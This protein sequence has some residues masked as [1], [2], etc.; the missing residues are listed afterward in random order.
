MRIFLTIAAIMSLVL[1]SFAMAALEEATAGAS[2]TVNTFVD[3][4]LTDTNGGGF[5]FGSDDPGTS[6]NAEADQSG[7]TPAATITREATSNVNVLVRLK[8]LDFTGAGT[9]A[10]NNAKFDD[11]ATVDQVTDTGLNQTRMTTAYPGS[12]YATLTSGSPTLDI[13][14][15]LDIPTSQ[16]AGAYTSTFSFEGN[17]A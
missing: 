17:S 3:I 4:T 15:W 7:G 5:A 11:D 1:V 14:F 10:I 16:A 9:I 2:V 12:A 6:N 8:G 13:W